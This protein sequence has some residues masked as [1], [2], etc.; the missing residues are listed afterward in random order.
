MRLGEHVAMTMGHDDVHRPAGVDVLAADDEGNLELAAGE[1]FQGPLELHSLRGPRGIAQHR[2]VDG[3]GD[4]GDDVHE[5]NLM[6]IHVEAGTARIMKHDAREPRR[7]MPSDEHN[8]PADP[9]W[10][11]P[12]DRVGPR[13]RPHVL[14]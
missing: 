5:G 14:P 8:R 10:P 12:P 2:L 11:R 7:V 4:L 9:R 6:G 3:Y 13:P 1:L